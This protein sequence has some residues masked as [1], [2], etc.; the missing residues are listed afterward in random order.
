MA[1]RE[2]NNNA[3]QR[4]RLRSFTGSALILTLGRGYRAG[5][6]PRR[7]FR[8]SLSLFLSAVTRR[9][10]SDDV[11]GKKRARF[12]GVKGRVFF[13][14]KA[15]TERQ[16]STTEENDYSF[17]K[18]ICRLIIIYETMI[19]DLSMLVS[20]GLFPAYVAGKATFCFHIFN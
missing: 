14:E 7:L 2:D 8:L 12:S 16:E 5:V 13:L 20:S 19:V 4:A 6:E 3:Q 17:R 10:G 18:Y 11:R 1:R 15:H 9:R